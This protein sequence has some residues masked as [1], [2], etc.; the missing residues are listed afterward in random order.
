MMG[1]M[2]ESGFAVDSDGSGD[3]SRE[4]ASRRIIQCLTA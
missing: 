3:R 2:S 4:A 1:M